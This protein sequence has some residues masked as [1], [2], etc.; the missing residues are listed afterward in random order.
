M[1]GI[2]TDVHGHVQADEK[3]KIIQGFFAAGECA[4]VSVHGANRLGT[5]SLLDAVVHGRRTGKTMKEY[6]R[7]AEFLPL[8]DDAGKADREYFDLLF[9]S[10]GKEDANKIR[11]TL[12]S[13]MMAKC[14]VFRNEKDL[15]ELIQTIEGMKDNFKHVRMMYKKGN[16]N[17]E[18]M[19]LMELRNLLEFSELIALGA[20][21]RQECR[22]AHWRI[23]FPKRDDV[24]WLKHTFAFKTDK[25]TKLKY[26]PVT[27]LNYQPQ[28][29]KY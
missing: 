9:K 11:T 23:D 4:C 6:L 15:K 16:F 2:P 18:L 12:K 17:T 3:G 22:G 8:P 19:E 29:R 26:K 24:K 7:D 10:E 1:G 20:H 14:G 27:I 25:G 28:E 5:N 13:E 21:E